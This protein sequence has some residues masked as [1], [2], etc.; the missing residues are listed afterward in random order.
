LSWRQDILSK[1]FIIITKP[2]KHTAKAAD[3]RLVIPRQRVVDWK[4][5]AIKETINTLEESRKAFKS[6][7]LEAFV[8][9]AQLAVEF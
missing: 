4:K 3:V 2:E 5:T 8:F 1:P 6:K 7:R 9:T